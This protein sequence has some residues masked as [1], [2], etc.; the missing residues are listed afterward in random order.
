MTYTPEKTASQLILGLG[1]PG[2]QYAG[3]RHNFGFQVLDT[4]VENR[5]LSFRKGAGSFFYTCLNDASGLQSSLETILFLCKPRTYMNQSGVA[6]RQALAYFDLPPQNMLVVYDDIDLPL[7][8]LRLRLRGSAGGHRGVESI[9][10]Q[11]NSSEFPRL[12]LGIGPQTE[13]VPA[14]EFVLENF[15]RQELPVRDKVIRKADE[16][17]IDL[18]NKTIR[19]LMND[20]NAIN[21][22]Q[23][24]IAGKEA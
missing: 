17:I 15:T 3:Q 11:I 19:S 13:G 5:D 4:L 14:E 7:G 23:Q 20:Y 8:K 6:A 18:G 2:R 9:I 24:T 16:L 10:N 12:K 21:L 22:N 1:N